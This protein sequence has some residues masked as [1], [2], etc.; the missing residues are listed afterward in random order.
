MRRL[1]VAASLQAKAD[2]ILNDQIA[3]SQQVQEESFFAK[4][5]N[6]MEAEWEDTVIEPSNLTWSNTNRYK[7][8][9]EQEYGGFMVFAVSNSDF[10]AKASAIDRGET[11]GFMTMAEFHKK[12]EPLP[13]LDEPV[14][15][16]EN[17]IENLVQKQVPKPDYKSTTAN[18]KLKKDEDN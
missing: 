18:L 14:E 11:R 15:Q 9:I 8:P 10:Q 12:M 1:K 7:F 6:I 17:D 5:N 3:P 16:Y 4:K 2:I 13:V